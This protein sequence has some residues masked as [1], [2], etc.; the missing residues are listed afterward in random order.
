MSSYRGLGIQVR[1][2]RPIRPL[3][4]TI[5]GAIGILGSLIGLGI[6]I[7]GVWS[8]MRVNVE[9]SRQF[10]LYSL[11]ALVSL[12]ALRINWGFWEQIKLAWWA[13]LLL[14]LV[15]I[16]MSVLALRA[17][18]DIGNLLGR[19]LPQIAASS[20]VVALAI[21]IVVFVYHLMVL[22]YM[23]VVRAAF[24]VG[25]KDERPLWEKVQRN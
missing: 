9:P 3:G 8:I 22:L 17:V 16:G 25:V 18:P 12:I 13:N 6:A 20:Y 19:V 23:V 2:V 10:G 11:G 24:G 1:T 7:I 5:I 4:V 15:G 21:A 14:T